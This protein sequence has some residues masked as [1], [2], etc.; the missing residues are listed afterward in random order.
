[1]LLA[2]SRQIAELTERLREQDERIVEL[3]R[4][5]IRQDLQWPYAGAHTLGH[6][7]LRGL[8]GHIQN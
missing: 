5:L 2:L 3:E 4:H 8:V 6:V 1:M 7:G